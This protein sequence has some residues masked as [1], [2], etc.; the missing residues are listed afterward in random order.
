M[1]TWVLSREVHE[2]RDTCLHHM[3][4]YSFYNAW[5]PELSEMKKAARVSSEIVGTAAFCDVRDAFARS[6]LVDGIGSDR[7]IDACETELR[8]LL[9]HN[10]CECENHIVDLRR[11][12]ET[13]IRGEVMTPLIRARDL[14]GHSIEILR[15]LFGTEFFAPMCTNLCMFCLQLLM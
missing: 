11:L 7:V 8:S 1:L 3:F 12:A 2:V 4:I 9:A 13:V 5:G 6:C 15:R 10:N 14:L